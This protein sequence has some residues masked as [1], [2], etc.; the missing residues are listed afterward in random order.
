VSYQP[1]G[2]LDHRHAPEME[3]ECGVPVL[4]TPHLLPLDRGIVSTMHPRL[5]PGATADDLRRCL[6]D[7]YAHA[8]FVRVLPKGAWPSIGGVAHTNY[9]DIAVGS[10]P[11]GRHAIVISAIDNL[12]KGASGQAVQ[13]FNLRFGMPETMALPGPAS[14]DETVGLSLGEEPSL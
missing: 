13:A 9:C 6:S 8:P 2:V 7:R 12:L 3:Q 5:A 10:D 4:F 11:S 1:Y 14:R